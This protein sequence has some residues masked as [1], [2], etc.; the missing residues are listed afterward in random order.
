MQMI[1]GETWLCEWCSTDD[2]RGFIANHPTECRVLYC[3]EHYC[4][5]WHAPLKRLQEE[6]AQKSRAKDGLQL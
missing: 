3:K 6:Q 5:T 1:Y 2:V 4:K